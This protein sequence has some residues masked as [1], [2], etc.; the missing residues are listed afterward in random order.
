MEITIRP[1]E[2]FIY[3]LF[4]LYSYKERELYLAYNNNEASVYNNTDMRLLSTIIQT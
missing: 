4:C 3:N 1:T 2:G